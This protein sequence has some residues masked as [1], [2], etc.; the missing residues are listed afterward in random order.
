[1]E[2]EWGLYAIASRVL[3][4]LLKEGGRFDARVARQCTSLLH[5]TERDQLGRPLTSYTQQVVKGVFQI[6]VAALQIYLTPS[7]STERTYDGRR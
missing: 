5:D 1:M 3:G 6:V 7:A 2:Q 4:M